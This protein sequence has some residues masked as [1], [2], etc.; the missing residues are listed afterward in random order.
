MRQI[1]SDT[2]TLWIVPGGNRRTRGRTDGRINIK[3][4]K[5]KAFGSHPVDVGCLGILVAKTGKVAPPH[6][7]NKDEYDIRLRHS[8]GG[9]EKRDYKKYEQLSHVE[10]LTDLSHRSHLFFPNGQ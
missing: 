4:F 9:V 5:A 1:G 6:V 8:E 2:P 7:I 3:L 10:K